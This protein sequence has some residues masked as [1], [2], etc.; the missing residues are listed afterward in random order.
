MEHGDFLT[1]STSYAFPSRTPL[2][3]LLSPLKTPSCSE[4]DSHCC[5]PPAAR[6][7]CLG[8]NC[9]SSIAPPEDACASGCPSSSA[10]SSPF[11][12][13]FAIPGDS[14]SESVV[15][16]LP[17]E[18]E[19]VNQPPS[20]EETLFRQT[21]PPLPPSCQQPPSPA[22]KLE[23]KICLVC[24]V[25][26]RDTCHA[27][28]ANS[29]E[30]PASQLSGGS[31]PGLR[32]SRSSSLHALLRKEA[33]DDTAGLTHGQ[34]GC[35]GAVRAKSGSGHSICRGRKTCSRSPATETSDSSEDTASS[36]SSCS[37]CSSDSSSN[38]RRSLSHLSASP[39]RPASSPCVP[40]SV[41]GCRDTAL[42]SPPRQASACA[43]RPHCLLS[44]CRCSASCFTPKTLSC[45]IRSRCPPD[46]RS[47]SSLCSA[48]RHSAPSSPAG[49]P[50]RRPKA[51]RPRGKTVSAAAGFAAST[52]EKKTG[53]ANSEAKAGG[54]RAPA[55]R[56]SP[57]ALARRAAAAEFA[58]IHRRQA[59]A[60]R[61]SPSSRTGSRKT[62][63]KAIRS[64]PRH[65]FCAQEKIES[66]AR[67]AKGTPKKTNE[68]RACTSPTAAAATAL[69]RALAA[70]AAPVERALATS[71]LFAS[72]TNETG[73]V[74]PHS[75]EPDGFERRQPKRG[76][77][78]QSSA[79]FQRLTRSSAPV[80]KKRTFST[81]ASATTA[82]WSVRG[83]WLSSPSSG[84]SATTPLRETNRVW[85][86]GGTTAC[87]KQTIPKPREVPQNAAKTAA[88]AAV[89]A[90]AA[91]LMGSSTGA[92]CQA[93][94][95]A[96]RLA[97]AA[98]TCV[99]SLEASPF[100]RLRSGEHGFIGNS[101]ATSISE[102]ALETARA[103]VKSAE[104]ALLRLQEDCCSSSSLESKQKEGTREKRV[105][106]RSFTRGTRMAAESTVSTEPTEALPPEK[107]AHSGQLGSPPTPCTG[108]RQSARETR[109]WS[110]QESDRVERLGEAHASE[111]KGSS[112][113]ASSSKHKPR[114]ATVAARA[115][116]QADIP[117]AE[118]AV[119]VQA[120][121]GRKEDARKCPTTP[122]ST[123]EA[124]EGDSIVSL[125]SS[126]KKEARANREAA[127]GKRKKST[128]KRR[129]EETDSSSS[130][131]A[132]GHGSPERDSDAERGSAVC[133]ALVSDTTE[134]TKPE[135]LDE[136]ARRRAG[137][138]DPGKAKGKRDKATH[139]ERE[140]PEASGHGVSS[141]SAAVPLSLPQ[142]ERPPSL[143]A[144]V[145]KSSTP[146]SRLA[147]AAAGAQTSKEESSGDTR[148]GD[149]LE[150]E[151][152]DNGDYS[153][154]NQSLG[155]EAGG[156]T[157]GK[158]ESTREA[159]S[160][161]NTQGEERK[162]D[163]KWE[164]QEPTHAAEETG[165]RKASSVSS[166]PS[167]GDTV[168]VEKT[169]SSKPKK[170]KKKEKQE[171]TPPK[172]EDVER[173]AA[174]RETSLSKFSD[175][176]DAE[177]CF[178]PPGSADGVPARLPSTT[179]TAKDKGGDRSQE[180]ERSTLPLGETPEASGAP[181][182]GLR[183]S[184]SGVQ[185]LDEPS[186]QKPVPRKLSN[187]QA[188]AAA[189]A[190]AAAGLSSAAEDVANTTALLRQHAEE[191][192]EAFATK[193]R[194]RRRKK[195]KE[196]ATNSQG[197]ETDRRG[198]EEGRHARGEREAKEGG[199]KSS[200]KEKK[201]RSS[202]EANG[203]T[204]KA[205]GDPPAAGHEAAKG[206]REEGE[207][208]AETKKKHGK[209]NEGEERGALQDDASGMRAM[210]N[211]QGSKR[212]KAREDAEAAAA[213]KF[214]LPAEESETQ[215]ESGNH[216]QAQK[217]VA[218][219]AAENGG[220]E[221]KDKRKKSKKEKD[222]RNEKQ[223][224][225]EENSHGGRRERPTSEKK[226][227]KEREPE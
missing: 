219:E 105:G 130:R 208:E 18:V 174:A 194:P 84:F 75:K 34:R 58:A 20:I 146:L 42:P 186:E 211:E 215:R 117:A 168:K 100:P 204:A 17:E 85:A 24:R 82:T 54:F 127:G 39:T 132:S 212:R 14:E 198:A 163:F 61:Q 185:T 151:T 9:G 120:K 217:P 99:A 50:P 187:G 2:L 178:S 156:K 22:F 30:R 31:T 33:K 64:S 161:R 188:H 6:P 176:N 77:K 36:P 135:H 179:E 112:T 25:G 226:K 207:R 221:A 131:A 3:P 80:K 223:D 183:R 92:S 197:Q 144:S 10:F 142:D 47:E 74:G 51:L 81:G 32:L 160:S 69:A 16:A 89:L 216:Q 125:Q 141:L 101:D 28:S 4:L 102:A 182:P 118:T 133:S 116:S 201:G 119:S 52:K 71:A 65:A 191:D 7:F 15:P 190:K 210:K 79:A 40:T 37:S 104:A 143:V 157:K 175:N 41:S 227:E 83:A 91:A 94:C 202:F 147:A 172:T 115:G 87:A 12:S 43:F 48:K 5:V 181:S 113:A 44:P 106:T 192:A 149:H 60:R 164:K 27:C 167:C 199:G 209:K 195:E 162:D 166:T 114:G 222:G 200:E 126:S 169:G 26:C 224:S 108:E 196:K 165:E 76:G 218:R 145:G 138:T 11:K 96:E 95:T 159:K 73:K 121:R 137:A 67:K 136:T 78:P 109:R 220:V 98:R 72:P 154:S 206:E 153:T 124:S 29:A 177:A 128:E 139:D 66:R 70:A 19:S 53:A 45:P 23:E 173:T 59:S 97:E 110:E 49:L 90:A 180:N 63:S 13:R 62:K 56:S 225:E 203:K 55:I 189:M 111:K 155:E 21:L 184:L 46:P 93:V 8:G 170:N 158:K 1:R 88:A 213:A 214:L 68:D 123:S 122:E 86:L 134:R 107:N 140:S 35:T 103:A 205:S 171:G 57:E 152:E 129:E 150:N 148:R 193:G 38:T